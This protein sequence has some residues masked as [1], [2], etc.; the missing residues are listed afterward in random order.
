MV[1]PVHGGVGSR[2]P[3]SAVHTSTFKLI[4]LRCFTAMW[5]EWRNINI[6]KLLTM[7]VAC[8]STAVTTEKLRVSLISYDTFTLMLSFRWLPCS[9]RRR[10][11]Q[12]DCD[13]VFNRDVNK[14]LFSITSS[15]SVFVDRCRAVVQLVSRHCLSFNPWSLALPCNEHHA[16]IL[17]NV[18]VRPTPENWFGAAV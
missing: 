5:A 1:Q 11:S 18:W 6:P 10:G 9:L 16:P 2:L 7:I 8:N 12:E 13:G 17:N 15:V 3:L 4:L 14:L